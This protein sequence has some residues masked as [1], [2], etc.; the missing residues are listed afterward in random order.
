MVPTES[1]YDKFATGDLDYLVGE[2]IK[3][4][5]QNAA[6]IAM[7][8]ETP[9]ADIQSPIRKC[10][11]CL[12]APSS[13]IS[14]IKAINPYFFTLANN[15]IF[16]QGAAGLESTIKLLVDNGIDFSGVGSNLTEARKP[17]IKEINGIKIGI[18]CCAEHE[19]S[20]AADTKAGANPYDP[21][22]SFD[23]VRDLRN[24]CEYLIV[25]YHGGKEHY[26]YPSP[27]LQKIFRKFADAGA[28][29]VIAQH[30]HCIG[31]MET[32]NDSTL[33]YGQ[34]NFLFDHSDSDFW[35]TSL[36]LEVDPSEKH[37]SFIPIIKDGDR[38]REAEGDEWSG[39]LNDFNCRSQEIAQ[40]GFIENRYAE[41]AD[42][43]EA[44]YLTR[45]S[46]GFGKN[47]FV[48]AFNKLTSYRF[49][50]KYYS[51]KYRVVIENVLDCE[52]HRELASK[53]L[54]EK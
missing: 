46:G 50:K 15:H 43:M 20:I 8:L 28:D 21:L 42:E 5:L 29:L 11:P 7:N 52:A 49:L 25:L 1:N 13:V 9:L 14:G 23:D 39:V 37:V 24:K 45:F 38:I 54:R 53:A 40:P 34:G 47:F 17:Y 12:I 32:Y 44:E 18:Y 36:L 27:M 48:R 26:R 16:D 31:C 51:D 4:R 2:K 22:E 30:T 33:V 35:K 10:G 19:Y 41:F 3:E 6:F